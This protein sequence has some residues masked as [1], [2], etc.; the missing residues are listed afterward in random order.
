[1]AGSSNDQQ[2]SSP[3]HQRKNP[4]DSS[5]S[6]AS[7]P[8]VSSGLPRLGPIGPPRR[9]PPLL[10]Q[11]ADNVHYA[12]TS[13]AV[14]RDP[15][16]LR[17]YCWTDNSRWSEYIGKE[18]CTIVN[19]LR[20]IANAEHEEAARASPTTQSLIQEDGDAGTGQDSGT[21][22]GP[23]EESTEKNADKFDSEREKQESL[24]PMSATEKDS[25]AE[26]EEMETGEDLEGSQ[27]EES[28]PREKEPG[29]E[30]GAQK[31]ELEAQGEEQAPYLGIH[32][33]NQFLELSEDNLNASRGRRGLPASVSS[34]H[35]NPKACAATATVDAS[36]SRE[37]PR[38]VAEAV[39]LLWLWFV[40]SF[41]CCQLTVSDGFTVNRG[42][43]GRN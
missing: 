19:R 22:D 20:R 26:K 13:R 8:F 2:P 33:R 35:P 41:S 42:P 6:A 16:Q 12:S 31:E 39:A 32:D 43:G 30:L 28:V 27:G 24:R 14:P 37:G 3:N 38:M 34:Y 5:N 4:G 9:S 25:E 23:E 40:D 7:S 36:G 1:M 29:E 11:G 18:I 15:Q 17:N 21:I 10:P